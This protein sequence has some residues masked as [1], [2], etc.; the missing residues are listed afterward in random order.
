MRLFCFPYAGGGAAIYR[1]WG[2]YLPPDIELCAVRLPGR[3]GRFTESPPRRIEAL[4]ALLVEGLVP[5]MDRS[6]GFFGHSLGAL[7]AFELARVLRRQGRPTPMHVFVSGRRAPNL[8]D[9]DEP[10]RPPLHTRPDAELLDELRRLEGTPS[11]V[12]AASELIELM[13]P[14]VRADFEIGE[15]YEYRAR[16]PVDCPITAF[17]GLGDEGVSQD[18]VAAW[19][20]QTRS[21]FVQ[22]MLPGSH[23]FLHTMHGSILD[24]IAHELGVASKRQA[25]Q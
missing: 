4:L 16:D 10:D 24:V 18:C 19:R 6:F 9:R 11:G 21:R 8:A 25:H 2:A 23:F 14:I 1:N 3:E 7:V 22:H 17:G 15:T 12:L 5:H 13:L 20:D